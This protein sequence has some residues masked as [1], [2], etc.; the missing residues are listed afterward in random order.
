MPDINNIENG[1]G[2]DLSQYLSK[3]LAAMNKYAPAVLPG[4]IPVL[5][6]A[7]LN[8][9]LT[10][11]QD[12]QETAESYRKRARKNMLYGGGIGALLGL[13]YVLQNIEKIQRR[14]KMQQ[15]KVD[16]EQWLNDRREQNKPIWEK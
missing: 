7:A 2:L 15:T 1:N 3:P 11:P 4:A 16:A 6:M 8:N 13:R 5:G 10:K 9:Y 12:P 14:D